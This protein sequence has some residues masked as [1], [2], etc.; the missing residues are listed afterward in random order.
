MDPSLHEITYVQTTNNQYLYDSHLHPEYLEMELV[1]QHKENEWF[2]RLMNKLN[3]LI[4]DFNIEK[5]IALHLGCSTGLV[6][7][8]LT[9]EFEKVLFFL[10]ERK[11]F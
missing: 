10:S 1:Y 8:E 11:R 2:E 7:F 5:N 3:G 9:K 4:R 6:A